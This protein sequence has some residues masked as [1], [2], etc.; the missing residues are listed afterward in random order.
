MDVTW[1]P[2]L[3]GADAD[4]ARA[5]IGTIADDLA[6]RTFDDGSLAHGAAGAALLHGTLARAGFEGE[7]ARAHAALARSLELLDA[8]SP[9]P[10]LG[11]GLVGTAWVMHQLRD[12]VDCDADTLARIYDV[13]SELLA[14]A[15]GALDCDLWAGLIGYGVF[16]LERGRID[17]VERVVAQLVARAEPAAGGAAWRRRDRPGRAPDGYIDLGMAH[18]VAGV[19]AFL[20][21][22]MAAGVN[23]ARAP[24]AA[25]A[26]WLAMQ[27]RGGAAPRFAMAIGIEIDPQN[28]CDGWCYGDLAIAATLQRAGA[29]LGDGDAI[30]RARDLAATAAG[31]AIDHV[32]HYDAGLCHGAASR[33]FGLAHLA[34]VLGDDRLGDAARRY[35]RAAIEMSKRETRSSLLV[36]TSGIALALLA[37]LSA[38]DLGWARLFLY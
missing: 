30:A 7:D 15:S 37:T 9:G 12:V 34:R 11:T 1:P 21:A 35:A 8:G 22:A 38:E 17:L 18:G 4:A 26:R 29:A 23:A 20:A 19:V 28:V 10:S 3:S 5:A 25:G 32:P 14:Q 33:A 24:A 36:G 13:V 16:A 31:A 27:D 6:A 2:L